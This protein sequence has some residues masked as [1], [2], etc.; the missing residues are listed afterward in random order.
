MGRALGGTAPDGSSWADTA[1]EWINAGC[2]L[3]EAHPPVRPLTLL[4][5][6]ARVAAHPTGHIH[7][8]GSVH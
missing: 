1:V 8:S 6:T 2:P 4:T 5:P 7:G 3:P